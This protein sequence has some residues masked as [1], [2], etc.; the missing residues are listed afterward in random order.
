MED[1]RY[2]YPNSELYIVTEDEREMARKNVRDMSGDKNPAWIDGNRIRKYSKEYYQIR[3]FVINRDNNACSVCKST[4]ELSVHHIDYNKLN[5]SEGN[6]ITLCKS[7]HAKTNWHRNIWKRM[8]ECGIF[9]YKMWRVKSNN[10]YT[11]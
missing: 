5:N 10:N 8:F 7:C 4:G 3:D 11:F 6:L 2:K 9:G 1:Y